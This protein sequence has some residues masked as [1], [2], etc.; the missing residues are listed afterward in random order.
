MI[1][2]LSQTILEGMPVYPSDEPVSLKHTRFL[3]TDGFNNSVL[4]Q[5]MH[6]GTHVDG[7]MHMSESA[8]TIDLFSVDR[9]YGSAKV[10]DV[11]GIQSIQPEHL[12]WNEI[13]EDDIIIFYT[14][15][16]VYYSQNKYYQDHPSISEEL[17]DK[18]IAKQIKMIGVDMP[19][20]DHS[21]FLVHKK[22]FDAGIFIVEN[23]TGLNQ[24]FLHN[25]VSTVQKV[26]FYALPLK[27][28]ADSSPVRAV[29]VYNE[30]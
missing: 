22:L 20:P 10:F 12:D 26:H 29:A 6:I 9:F 13:Q 7:L 1:V 5:G 28:A 11:C 17:A 18:I 16:D 3:N 14:G 24:I 25:A 23:L 21:P 30:T 4:K 15:F 19:S 27:I 2:D 8:Q